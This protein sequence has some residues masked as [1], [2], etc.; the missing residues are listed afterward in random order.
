[1]PHNRSAVILAEG[2][3]AMTR[4]KIIGAGLAGLMVLSVL[5]PAVASAGGQDVRF[6]H[7]RG[8]TSQGGTMSVTTFVTGATTMLDSVY[9]GLVTLE[10]EDGTQVQY[11]MGYGWG[12]GLPMPAERIDVDY[13]SVFDAIHMHGRLGVHGGSG[14]FSYTIP[15]LTADEQGAQLCTTGE[16]TWQ[17]QRTAAATSSLPAAGVQT[18]TT[19]SPQG[20]T[21]TIITSGADGTTR[22]V[23]KSGPEGTTRGVITSGAKAAAGTSHLRKYRGRTSQSYPMN[24]TTAKVDST[25][26]LRSLKTGMSLECEDG[27]GS[28]WIAGWWFD[29]GLTLSPARL[30]YDEVGPQG[31]MHVH[32]R[33]GTHVG[34]GTASNASA[35]LTADEQAQFCTTGELTWRMWR[36]DAGARVVVP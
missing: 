5:V 25:I 22:T 3:V 11:G 23:V 20:T 6:R 34:S 29:P 1:L 18:L 10:C 17:L 27:T 7:Y 19:S 36:T 9:F 2:V 21:R 28:G 32:G 30:D 33:L 15:A 12:G 14:T 13:V 35:A 26:E 24:V 31:A 4:M 8:T 16:L